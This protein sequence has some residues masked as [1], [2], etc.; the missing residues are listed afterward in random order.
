M[1]LPNS[2]DPVPPMSVDT[3]TV[4]VRRMVKRE[5]AA[6]GNVDL[7]IKALARRYKIGASQLTHLFKGRAKTYDTSKFARLREAYFDHC[8]AQVAALQ[9]EIAVEKAITRD[10]DFDD[11]AAQAAA[12]AEK[13]AAKRTALNKG[14]EVK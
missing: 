13:I 5:K 9:Q 3:A 10:D 4:Y 7:A 8:A 12:L 11:L 14:R 1:A 2:D 6:A